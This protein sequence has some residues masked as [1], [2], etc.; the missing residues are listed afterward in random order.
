VF[1]T[2]VFT[3]SVFTDKNGIN[4]FVRGFITIDGTTRT[5]VSIQVEGTTKGQVKRDVT[6]TDGSSKGALESNSTLTNTGNGF[7]RNGS[8]TILDN[9][10]DINFFP[11]D[12][13][14]C[15]SKDF[16]D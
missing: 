7:I 5:D 2:R 6:L 9:R 8:L 3:F 15:S 1:N 14:L 4:I 16:L 10:C 11:F 12:R 13:S